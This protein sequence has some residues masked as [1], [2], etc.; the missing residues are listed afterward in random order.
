MG[1]VRL[2]SS[3]GGIQ[4]FQR[5]DR[6]MEGSLCVGRVTK[7]YHKNHTADV[8]L[9]EHRDQI[10]GSNINDGISACK[11][12][13]R[14]AGWDSEYES[15]YGDSTP[16]QVGELVVVGF[17]DNYKARPIIIGTLHEF[18]SEK[19]PFPKECP[20][21]EMEQEQK[22]ARLSV[23]RTQD[24]KLIKGNGEMELAHHSK[25]FLVS[26]ERDL[27]DSKD[28]FDYSDLSVK[29]K[30]TDEVV[31]IPESKRPFQ[32]LDFLISLRDSLSSAANFL[33]LWISAKTGEFRLSKL[34]TDSTLT[35][36]EISKDGAFTVARQLDSN[37]RGDSKNY[38]KISVQSDGEI[39]VIRSIEGS[40]T[41]ISI[42]KSGEIQ[43]SS[44]NS[45]EISGSKG[46]TISSSERINIT[47]PI[48]NISE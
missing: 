2:Q 6:K 31:E 19:N 42:G 46:V 25:A 7:V 39:K 1:D 38:S 34:K 33:K 15:F 23:S 40:N 28:G 44:K 4:K 24:Y 18:K 14:H 37:V 3:L 13:E 35:T 8:V 47:A 11:I 22:Y 41:I 12:L 29:N 26:S 20:L 5:K 43:M 9:L 16:I 45:V 21:D 27:D 10:V 17:L 32:P 48:V 30:L 36:L